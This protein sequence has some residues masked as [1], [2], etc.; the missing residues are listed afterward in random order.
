MYLAQAILPVDMFRNHWIPSQ[1]IL[2]TRVTLRSPWN[3]Y[4]RWH[5]LLLYFRRVSN[6]HYFW[7]K[8]WWTSHTQRCN[9]ARKSKPQTKHIHPI[10]PESWLNWNQQNTLL[11]TQLA[12]H[13][14]KSS[15]REFY[16][17][18]LIIMVSFPFSM[19]ENPDLTATL[20]IC[21]MLPFSVWMQQ[22]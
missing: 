11:E 1:K 13:V 2:Q 7:S 21:S 3:N 15:K 17:T 8:N 14:P 12:K 9:R 16:I 19:R 22:L 20:I 6:K 18:F 4:Q 5:R 10:F